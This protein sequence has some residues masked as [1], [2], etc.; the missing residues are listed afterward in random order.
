MD[1]AYAELESGEDFS[2]QW[3]AVTLIVVPRSWD[4]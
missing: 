3:C 4:V 2:A 1:V